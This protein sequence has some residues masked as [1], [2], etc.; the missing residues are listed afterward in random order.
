MSIMRRLRGA[1]GIA[2]GWAIGWGLAGAALAGPLSALENGASPTSLLDRLFTFVWAGWYGLVTG[3][4]FA[5]VLA[6][7]ARRRTFRELTAGR[8]ASWGAMAG[9]LFAAPPMAYM[10]VGRMLS[11]SRPDGL[12][13][14]DVAYLGGIFVLS[15]LCALGSLWIA[16]R[17]DATGD[18][19][20]EALGPATPREL[21]AAETEWT[22]ANRSPGAVRM[23]RV[24]L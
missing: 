4:L 15:V 5:G 16:R 19:E 20:G 8:M 6:F 21:N 3:L 2:T 17:A 12:R 14:D 13:A 9:V 22:A 11:P 1:L 18:K 23:P 10:L 7:A 24:R